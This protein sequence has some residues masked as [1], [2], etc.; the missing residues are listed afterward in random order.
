MVAKLCQLLLVGSAGT[1]SKGKRLLISPKTRSCG[2]E[3]LHPI[4][5]VGGV[6]PTLVRKKF[7][8]PC[9]GKTVGPKAADG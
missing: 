1:N 8:Y 6:N 3:L 4:C 7:Q 5:K 2:R 9:G